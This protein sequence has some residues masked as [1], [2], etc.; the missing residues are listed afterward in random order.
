MVLSS[1]LYSKHLC[2]S[3]ASF[4]HRRPSNRPLLSLTGSFQQRGR[5]QRLAAALYDGAAQARA[6]GRPRLTSELRDVRGG[7]AADVATTTHILA[8]PFREHTTNECGFPQSAKSLFHVRVFWL[9]DDFAGGGG[10]TV[11]L[12]GGLVGFVTPRCYAEE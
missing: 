3:A 4:L 1:T 9:P 11:P 7:C 10:T 2:R 6:R 5:W 8:L 12:S